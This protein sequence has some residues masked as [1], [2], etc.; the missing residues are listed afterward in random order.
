MPTR[1]AQSR[2]FCR[3]LA[4]LLVLDPNGDQVGRVHD[5]IVAL[6]LGHEPP[7]VLGLA[8]EVQRRPI[9]VPIGRVTGVE[10][11]AV[12]LSSARLSWRRFE[13]RPNETR[14]LAELLDRRVRLLGP[15]ESAS[16]ATFG[17]SGS[18]ER[19]GKAEAGG[20]QEAKGE[21]VTVVD[22]AIE[23]VRGGDWVLEQVAVRRGRGRRGEVR[24]VSWDDVSGFSLPEEGQ[25]AANLLAAFEKLRPADLAGLLHDLSDKRRAEVAAALDDERLADVLEELPEDEQVELLGGLAEERAADVLEAMGPD[26][27]ADLLGELPAEDAE[28]LLRLMDPDE[29]AGVRRLLL[30]ADDS[31]GG[32]MTSE[33]VV[34]PPNAT[35]AEALARIRE[36]ELSPAL[37]AQVYV[38][39]PPCETPTGR[40]LGLAHFQRLLREP[41]STL[42]GGVIEVDIASLR[43]DTPLAEVTRHLASYNLVAAPVLDGAGRLV[44]VV[45]VDDVLDHLLPADWRERQLDAEEVEARTVPGAGTPPAAGGDDPG[46][47]GEVSAGAQL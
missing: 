22:A 12:V 26:D 44:G 14:V 15:G 39:R 27:A 46:A 2:V 47:V 42:V 41:P 38:V 10:S 32:I 5:V 13:Q 9:F 24:T 21:E 4:G 28:R 31:A 8:V 34:L 11:G 6:R 18:S 45:T 29:A 3:R 1:P 25:G 40:Y 43:P 33:P 19:A 36:P 7:R 16:R 30:Y 37:A 17:A 23:P 20:G 35:V